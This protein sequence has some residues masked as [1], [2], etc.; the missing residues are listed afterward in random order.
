MTHYGFYTCFDNTA[1]PSL[2]H[3]SVHRESR[4]NRVPAKCQSY[5][6]E[7]TRRSSSITRLEQFCWHVNK[8]WGLQVTR[9]RCPEELGGGEDRCPLPYHKNCYASM[10]A[11]QIDTHTFCFLQI[12]KNC[13]CNKGDFN[14][15][16]FIMADV[17]LLCG[18]SAGSLE[19]WDLWGGSP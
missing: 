9:R 8:R 19:P 6:Q 4:V 5:E 13:A 17:Y 7:E 3:L 1:W 12:P 15:C 16:L 18:E 2:P 10:K 11:K 14:L